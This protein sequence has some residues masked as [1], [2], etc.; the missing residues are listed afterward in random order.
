MVRR[1]GCLKPGNRYITDLHD[2]VQKMKELDDICH[3]QTA[4]G[5]LRS[6]DDDEKK[7]DHETIC[8]RS[9]DPGCVDSRIR[10]LLL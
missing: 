1:S 9:V 4:I 6:R 5:A 8:P 7:E 10:P 2:I 3:D